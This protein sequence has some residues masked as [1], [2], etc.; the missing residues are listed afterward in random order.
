MG[1][2]LLRA[3]V[4][5]HKMRTLAA[6]ALGNNIML[7]CPALDFALLDKAGMMPQWVFGGAKGAAQLG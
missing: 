5:Q 4:G 3:D 2:Y 1:L 7:A 6:P